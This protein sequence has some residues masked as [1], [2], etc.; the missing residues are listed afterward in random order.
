MYQVHGDAGEDPTEPPRSAPYPFPAVS[1]EPRIQ[2]LA[3]DLKR[4][5][6]HPF[7]TPAGIMLDEANMPF[8]SCVRCKDCDASRAWC[9][10]SRTRKCSACG[11]RCSI[12]TWS[13]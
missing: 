5:G 12:R 8:S 1:H 3:D 7:H 11:Q 9:M 4:S 10:R 2:K 13:W 6:F